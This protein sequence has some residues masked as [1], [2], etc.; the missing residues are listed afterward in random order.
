MQ[1]ARACAAFLEEQLL[2]RDEQGHLRAFR[3]LP[4]ADLTSIAGFLEDYASLGLGFLALHQCSLDEHYLSLAENLATSILTFFSDPKAPGFFQTAS[5][6][7]Q[8]IARRKQEMDNVT[9]SGNVMAHLLLYRLGRIL[10][11]PTWQAL[12]QPWL[13]SLGDGPADYPTGFGGALQ[14][15]QELLTPG[16]EVTLVGDLDDKNLRQS[17]DI[18]RQQYHPG[19]IFMPHSKGQMP[20]INLCVSGTCYPPQTTVEGLKGLLATLKLDPKE[21][22]LNPSP[23]HD[24]G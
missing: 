4:G 18:F 15:M 5:D 10:D 17:L 12:A 13:Q 9:P 3:S 22:D 1:T 24:S 6:A 16:I 19:L 7:E 20:S 21:T 14:L 23:T 8:L 2:T 11:Q